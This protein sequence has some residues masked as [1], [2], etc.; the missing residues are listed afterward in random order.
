MSDHGNTPH[1]SF[2]QSKDKRFQDQYRTVYKSFFKMPQTMKEVS[3]RTGIDRANIC[4]YCREMRKRGVIRPFKITLCRITRHLATQ[5][6]TNP[7]LFP[8]SAQLSLL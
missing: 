6:T 5:W 1:K 8:K 2:R 3:V 4:W 7:E